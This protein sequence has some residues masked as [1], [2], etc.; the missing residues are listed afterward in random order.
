VTEHQ[1]RRDLD[2]SDEEAQDGRAVARAL[3]GGDTSALEDEG[4]TETDDEPEL[5]D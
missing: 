4:D 2:G 5:F 1:R 3:Y